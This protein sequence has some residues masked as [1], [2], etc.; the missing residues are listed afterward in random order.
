MIVSSFGVFQ[1]LGLPAR[2]RRFKRLVVAMAVVGFSVVSGTAHVQAEIP[3]YPTLALQQTRMI[4]NNPMLG[5]AVTPRDLEGLA[6]VPQNNSLWM[7]DDN[8]KALYEIDKDSGLL[9]STI[10]QAQ[11]AA[12]PRYGASDLAGTNTANDFE[13]LVYN[14]QTD[15]LLA[16][17]GPCCSTGIRSAVFRLVRSGNTFVPQSFQP[18][19]APINDF[20]G[21]G[22]TNGEIRAALGSVI[23]RYTFDTNTFDAPV[24]LSQKEGNVVG[25]DF[26]DNGN[27]LWVTTSYNKI[28]R[29][30]WAT[31]TLYPNHSLLLSTV[32]V[33]DGRA[34][35][36]INDQ[37]YIADG[38]DSYGTTSPNK[39]A[40]HVYNVLGTAVAP[41]AAFTATPTSGTSP[42]NV[43]F[44]DTSTGGPTAW[45]WA[46]GDGGSSLAQHPSHT[47][48]APGTYTAT[49]MVGNANGSTIAT[50][51]ITVTS[52]GGGTAPTAAFTATP[53]AGV[54]PLNV[55]FTDTS[56]GSPTAWSWAFGDGG[57]STAQHPS[58]VYAVPGSYTATLMVG[59]A[60][61]S[62]VTTTT[63]TVTPGG[64][65]G[66][67]ATFLA[68][69]DTLISSSSP[70]K[71]YGTYDYIRGLVAYEY[72]PYVQFEVSGL[73]GPVT[74][75][76]LR[77]YVTDG[78][79][80]VGSWYSV[81]SGW[82]EAT[83]TWNT[84]PV[85]GGSPLGTVG[86]VA[87]GQWMEVNVTAAVTGNGTF[88]FANIPVST[89]S[90]R[91]SSRQGLN[92]PQL[93]VTTTGP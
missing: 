66:G 31:N 56:A 53:P 25:I 84:A 38:Y 63:I 72:R 5:S 10:T 50:T 89:N 60:N 22:Y 87:V 16:F 93:I 18:L 41:T 9:K 48:T 43:Q 1:P 69:Q 58:H 34:V 37:L 46:F 81:A 64:G 91:W 88:S 3:V 7:A 71:N 57:T 35:E 14:P 26:S 47:Y 67:S 15:Q 74:N 62:T 54:A 8:R 20:S 78:T 52:G 82:T 30:N 40:V 17:A 70:T 75:A 86:A 68:S 83:A 42:L 65:G 59:N 19:T 6:Y 80:N 85:A 29:Y 21:V 39:Y 92:P 23:Y 12:T 33:G 27:D 61:G 73:G 44:T 36:I 28:R 77:L 76:V 45:S 24:T 32:G 13:G 4:V 51:T 11:L 90:V 49:L 2:A 79:D 55:Q